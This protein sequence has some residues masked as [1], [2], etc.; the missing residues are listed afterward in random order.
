MMKHLKK[1]KK[2]KK[3]NTCFTAC[4]YLVGA[5]FFWPFCE[6]DLVRESREMPGEQVMQAIK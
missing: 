5:N 6:A 3:K 2:N 4:Q 1:K